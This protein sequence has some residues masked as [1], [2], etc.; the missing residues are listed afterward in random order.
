MEVG[1]EALR[2]EVTDRMVAGGASEPFF[3]LVSR[4]PLLPNCR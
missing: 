2:S 1:S 3:R 4:I